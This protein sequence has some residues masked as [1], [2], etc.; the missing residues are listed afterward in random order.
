VDENRID[1]LLK[2]AHTLDTAE[3]K[4][5]GGCCGAGD[6]IRMTDAEAR[7]IA[8]RLRELAREFAIDKRLS[9]HHID[10]VKEARI[11]VT[12]R[13]VAEVRMW[14]KQRAYRDDEDIMLTLFCRIDH[15]DIA[16]LIKPMRIGVDGKRRPDDS[17]YGEY[18]GFAPSWDKDGV[19]LTFERGH[20]YL[21][22]KAFWSFVDGLIRAMV[23]DGFD[24]E[25][26]FELKEI[27]RM[28][29]N[30]DTD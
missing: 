18:Y 9:R 27:V 24:I 12:N 16:G 28:I 8:A 15:N 14:L 23:D 21:G 20:F 22:S 26:W 2:I 13:S 29:D 5:T 30:A 17:L 4:A 10:S 11:H 25:H 1:W 7:E 6:W 19:A 3:R